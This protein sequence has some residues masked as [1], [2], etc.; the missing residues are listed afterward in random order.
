MSQSKRLPA[1]R[2]QLL[3]VAT[4]SLARGLPPVPCGSRTLA[5][6]SGAI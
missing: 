3:P 1:G 2:V 5:R 6:S 4:G